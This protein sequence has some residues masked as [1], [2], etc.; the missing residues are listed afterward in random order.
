VY[1]GTSLPNGAMFCGECGRAVQSAPA[2]SQRSAALFAPSGPRDTAVI[3]PVRPET[4]DSVPEIGTF[5]GSSRTSGAPRVEQMPTPVVP[6]AP[7]A[8]GVPFILQFSTGEVTTITGSGL[9]GRNPTPQP[10]EYFDHLVAI[11]DPGKS[12]SKT[13]LEFGQ[14]AGVLWVSDRFSGNGSVLLE[15]GLAPH[16]CEPGHR[17]RVPRGSRIDI[18]E[19]F[20]IVS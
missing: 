6:I 10:G 13:H 8:P 15:P 1:C 7:L 5:S 11:V 9:L 17:Y 12:V 4:T 20:V 16:R 2:V 14:E 3:E 18:A 19:Q